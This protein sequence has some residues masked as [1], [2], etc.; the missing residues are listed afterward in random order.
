MKKF[1]ESSENAL[2]GLEHVWT[3]E[4]NFRI[5]CI[6][7]VIVIFV[8]IILN[9]DTFR[10]VAIILCIVIVLSLEIVNSAIEYT[11]DHLEP[12]HHPVVGTIKDVMASAVLVASIGAAVVGILIIFYQ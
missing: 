7:S 10:W 5:H 4:I 2:K 3:E 11:W 1:I 8:G 12:N 6:I 9:F